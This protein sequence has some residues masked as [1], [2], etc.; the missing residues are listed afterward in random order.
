MAAVIIAS[1][2][3]TP[4]PLRIVLGSDAHAF[5]HTALTERLAALEAQR[6]VAL[7]TDFP[8]EM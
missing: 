5:I 3:Q 6:D 1:V 4:A 7:S 2:S 8:A